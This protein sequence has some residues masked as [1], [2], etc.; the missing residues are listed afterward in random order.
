MSTYQVFYN[1]KLAKRYQDDGDDIKL[2]D[3]IIAY[4][5]LPFVVRRQYFIAALNV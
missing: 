5:Y 4:I 3:T 1:N 2:P